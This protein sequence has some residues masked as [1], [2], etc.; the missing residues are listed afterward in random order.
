[1]ADDVRKRVTY[2]LV[3]SYRGVMLGDIFN[4]LD[5]S[6]EGLFKDTWRSRPTEHWSGFG[7]HSTER[8]MFQGRCVSSQ[9]GMH[10]TCL[11][12]TFLS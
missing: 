1:M 10:V 4:F 7:G 9:F 3:Q 6:V 11:N 5:Y 12:C 2:P 8:N